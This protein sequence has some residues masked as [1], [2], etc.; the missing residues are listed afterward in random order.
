MLCTSEE[1][2]FQMEVFYIPSLNVCYLRVFQHHIKQLNQRVLCVHALIF[3]L[4]VMVCKPTKQ[5][6][7]KQYT[8]EQ[9]LNKHQ[10]LSLSGRQED[11]MLSS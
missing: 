3:S 7:S 4:R 11:P 6:R 2:D 10:A 8:L 9:V 5:G 1:T